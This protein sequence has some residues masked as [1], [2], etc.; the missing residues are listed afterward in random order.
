MPKPLLRPFLLAFCWM[1]ALTASAQGLPKHM[2]E[3]EK[4]LMPAY[5]E[6]V[7]G[8]EMTTTPPPVPVRTMSEWEEVDGLVVTWASYAAILTEVV[9]H[10]RQETHV[11]II[12]SDSN[13]VKG[14]LVNG[15]VPLSNISFV[16]APFNSV[17]VRDYGPWN[18]YT[19][20]VDSLYIID[21]IYNRPRP[22]DNQIPEVLA[23]LTGLP[24]YAMTQAPWDLLQTGGNL[25]VDGFGKGFSSNLVVDENP[26][27]SIPQIDSIMQAFMGVD[28]YI[29]MSNLP[30]DNIHHIDMHM[31]LLDEETILVGKFPDGVSDGPQIE[32]NMLYVLNN[33]SSVFGTPYR[34]VWVPMCPSV[35]GQYPPNS[36]YRTYTNSV[37]VNNTVIV[38]TY[39]EQYDTTALRIYREAMPGYNVVGI[40]CNSMINAS[41]A[42][43]CITKELGAADPLLI[44]H[45]RLPN[46]WDAT[47]GYNLSAQIMHRSGIAS[48]QLWYRT[49]TAQPY[50]AISMVDVF[51][52]PTWVAQIP[53]QAPGTQVYYYIEAEAVSGKRQ[54]RPMPAPAGYWSFKVLQPTGMEE[55]LMLEMQD[56]FPNPSKG[57]TCIP[58][59]AAQQQRILISLTDLT[60]REVMT[61][62]EG[63]APAGQSRYFVDTTTLPG[64]MY[65]VRLETP[66]GS[67][68]QK[69]VVR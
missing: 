8:M 18:A 61:L 68:G 36:A 40:N 21:W 60:G 1:L 42:I 26:G 45:Q 58:I 4:A 43:H 6:T 53:A 17:W 27:K 5:L 12:C 59:H 49:D 67:T 51:G 69:L 28:T 52:G 14:S 7:R 31:K 34:V 2:T 24:R 64:G 15:A 47:A 62:F 37:I 13:Q 3:A 9:R 44:T 11:Y 30:F 48:A 16:V 41:G 38:P 25:M 63:E 66:N 20:D 54:V 10:A 57:I 35:T 29:K 50:Q 65:M 33:F 56:I 32:A 46:T 23:N 39:Y 22:L 55:V 19:N